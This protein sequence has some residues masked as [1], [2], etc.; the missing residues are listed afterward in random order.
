MSATESATKSLWWITL[1]GL[2][3]SCCITLPHFSCRPHLGTLQQPTGRLKSTENADSSY[4]WVLQSSEL[5][6]MLGCTIDFWSS[7]Q[8]SMDSLADPPES[9]GKPVVKRGKVPS[10]RASICRPC[11]AVIGILPFFMSTLFLLSS[12]RPLAVFCQP[13]GAFCCPY[14]FLSVS[15][16]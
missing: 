3:W 6:N 16:R 5:Q 2:G 1:W 14:N 9:A 15:C 4:K 12:C 11:R 7:L 13:Y 8:T 10:P